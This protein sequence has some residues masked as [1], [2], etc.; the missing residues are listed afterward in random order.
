MNEK[1]KKSKK[2]DKQE[3]PNEMTLIKGYRSRL[4]SDYRDRIIPE[5][6]KQFSYQN[7]MQV[8]KLQKIVLNMGIGEGSRDQKLVDSLKENLAEIAGQKP[9]ITK[10]KKSISNFK[11]R[12]GMSVGCSVTLRRTRMFDFL[13]RFMNI[14]IP[15]IRDFRGLSPRSFDGR[16]NYSMG[17]QEQ[18]IFPEIHYDRIARVQGMDIVIVTTANTDEEAITLLRLFG[19]P[20]RN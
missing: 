10:A 12:E 15:R 14:C 5:L 8:P 18:L 3:Q 1:K 4:E 2:E 20:F 11:L 9:I 7:V 17:I 16:G 6:I 13:D 19:M